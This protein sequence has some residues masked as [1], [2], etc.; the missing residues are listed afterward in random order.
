MTSLDFSHR[1]LSFGLIQQLFYVG[2]EMRCWLGE[3]VNRAGV[4]NVSIAIYRSAAKVV[5]VDLHFV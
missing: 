3:H 4:P 1:G 2:T 5:W